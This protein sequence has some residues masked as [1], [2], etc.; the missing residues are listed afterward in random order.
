MLKWY[1]VL[2]CITSAMLHSSG[3]Q[4]E[5]DN[6]ITFF[7]IIFRYVWENKHQH[8]FTT[9]KLE[10]IQTKSINNLY[11][12]VTPFFFTVQSTSRKIWNQ[13]T[14]NG[15]VYPTLSAKLPWK[16]T[17]CTSLCYA[18]SYLSP[19]ELQVTKRFSLLLSG[20]R[21]IGNGEKGFVIDI[22]ISS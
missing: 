22:L 12:V 1:L 15:Y 16:V 9:M 5:N 2:G 19:T 8:Q 18:L 14:K 3:L 7:P 11:W 21:E 13:F 4:I 17:P 20:R 6:S 10:H